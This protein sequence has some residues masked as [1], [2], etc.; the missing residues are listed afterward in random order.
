[1][2]TNDKQDRTII[3]PINLDDN[4]RLKAGLEIVLW[5]I[6]DGETDP[7]YEH[8]ISI[9]CRTQTDIETVIGF[10]SKDG[11]HSFRVSILEFWSD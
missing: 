2:S 8:A 6:P 4:G 10:A 3:P 7:L 11:W 1:M 9:Q 5:A